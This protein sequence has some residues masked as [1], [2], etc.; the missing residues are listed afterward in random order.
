MVCEG[1]S[2]V[3]GLGTKEESS[4]EH[5]NSDIF[6]F[7]LSRTKN[8]V[9]PSTIQNKPK[10]YCLHES[11]EQVNVNLTSALQLPQFSV[12]A[13]PT[14]SVSSA[15]RWAKEAAGKPRAQGDTELCPHHFSDLHDFS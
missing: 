4:V 15:P 7:M 11:L 9:S 6:F 1:L 14:L 10:C 3:T 12:A 8:I 2:G 13:A 5:D